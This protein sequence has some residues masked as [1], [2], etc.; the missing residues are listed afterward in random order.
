MTQFQHPFSSMM[1]ESIGT[2][3]S[4]DQGIL[5]RS[6]RILGKSFQITSDLDSFDRLM[7]ENDSMNPN[8]LLYLPPGHHVKSLEKIHYIVNGSFPN[9]LNVQYLCM[10]SQ[11]FSGKVVL[12]FQGDVN[13]E[14]K[15][16]YMKR[17]TGYDNIEVCNKSFFSL[18]LGDDIKKDWE[19][20]AV[21]FFEK[22]MFESPISSKEDIIETVRK[23]D[24]PLMVF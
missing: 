24:K 16:N 20:I 6:A 18:M 19:L 9:G 7:E 4:S 15:L 12:R 10:L 8:V 14:K 5:V 11:L 21:S 3:Y 2:E 1:S 23:S 17:V 22:S 13:G